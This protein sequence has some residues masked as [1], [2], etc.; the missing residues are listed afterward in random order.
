M[1]AEA[2]EDPLDAEQALLDGFLNLATPEGFR[3]E[4]LEGEITVVPPPAGVHER[5]ISSVVTQVIRSAETPMSVS[6]NRGVRLVRGASCPKNH[7]IPDI[8]FAPEHLDLFLDEDSWADSEGIAMVVEVTS[9]NAHRDRV[10]KR[11]CYAKAGVPLYL[12]V[13]RD[14]KATV[15]FALPDPEAEDY[16]ETCRFAFGLEVPLPAPFSFALDTSRF[17]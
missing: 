10:I 17:V 1:S 5:A 12:L 6:G 11:R 8:V 9:S 7:V 14:E 13:D 2:I 4:L 16:K 3:A 15:L